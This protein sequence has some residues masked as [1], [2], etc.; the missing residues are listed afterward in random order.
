MNSN[1]V[2]RQFFT[3]AIILAIL[4]FSAESFALDIAK[5]TLPN[6]LKVFHSERKNLPIVVLTLLIKTSSLNETDEKAGTAS[7]TAKLL[8]EG[9]T[10]RSSIQISEEI[11]FLG[12][13]IGAGAN[14]DYTTVSLG[15]LKKDLQK[16]FELFADILLKPSFPEEELKRKKEQLKGMLKRQEDEPG[17]LADKAFIREVFGSH[18]YGRLSEG[19]VESIDKI[20]RKD[21]ADFYR[22]NYRPDN[23]LLT[24]A[25]DISKTELD[26]LIDRYLKSWTVAEVAAPSTHKAPEN[27]QRNAPKVVIIDKNITQANIILGHAGISRENP[28]YYA[29]SVMNYILGGGGFASRLMKIVRDDMGLAYSI[30]SSFASNK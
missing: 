12:A 21:L 3:T 29:V 10:N 19:S 2:I 13:S 23:A 16:G 4:S 8:T 7:L 1:K 9:T 22:A 25:G 20:T 11:D 5:Q 24:V 6:G 14:K 27:I 18:P 30:H 15:V 26:A 17:F 28:D